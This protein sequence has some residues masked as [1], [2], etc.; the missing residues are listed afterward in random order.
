L[1]DFLLDEGK[2]IVPFGLTEGSA[3]VVLVVEVEVVRHLVRQ[4]EG[5]DRL[6]KEKIGLE[7]KGERV[8]VVALSCE[9]SVVALLDML[10]AL[11]LQLVPPVAQAA[12][13]LP[14]SLVE[15]LGFFDLAEKDKEVVLDLLPF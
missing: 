11:L 9:E 13:L 12:L 15:D 7:R 8:E 3:V 5:F 14:L 2:G 4:L 6:E 10:L 1:P